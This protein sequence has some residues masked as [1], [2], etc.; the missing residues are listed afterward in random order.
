MN[1]VPDIQREPGN[2]VPSKGKAALK[3]LDKTQFAVSLLL[4]CIILFLQHKPSWMKTAAEGICPF[5][6]DYQLCCSK[7]R[8][9]RLKRV[10]FLS[11][12]LVQ[13][14][15]QNVLLGCERLF[16]SLWGVLFLI[17]NAAVNKVSIVFPPFPSAPACS[18]KTPLLL[19]LSSLSNLL[20]QMMFSLA[21]TSNVAPIVSG[22]L[23]DSSWVD[24]SIAL[25]TTPAATLL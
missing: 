5:A 2:V 3:N 7:L 12:S 25:L 17:P 8:N 11:L 18:P 24:F 14:L 13:Q 9:F 15:M 21:G 16:L 23:R 10:G 1:Q 4:V 19:S 20:C 6:V 22:L